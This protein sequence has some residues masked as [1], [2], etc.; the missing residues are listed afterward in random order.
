[1]PI[2]KFPVNQSAVVDAEERSQAVVTKDKE[3]PDPKG[4]LT[5]FTDSDK[6]LLGRFGGSDV[7]ERQEFL[8]PCDLGLDDT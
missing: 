3:T 2:L 7:S 6:R 1:M 5:V 4:A 8:G